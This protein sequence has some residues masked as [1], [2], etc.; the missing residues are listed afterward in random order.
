[1]RGTFADGLDTTAANPDLNAA[2]A[3]GI[4]AW[5][6]PTQ[7]DGTGLL[8]SSWV[9]RMSAATDDTQQMIEQL[10]ATEQRDAD[11][12]PIS[13]RAGHR[14]VGEQDRFRG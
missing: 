2:I 12:H 4:L 8:R 6:S 3:N 10:F 14:R 5:W 9:A 13:D 1:M 11:T 7:F